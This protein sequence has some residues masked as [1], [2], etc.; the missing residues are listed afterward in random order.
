MRLDA[1]GIQVKI[2]IVESTLMGGEVGGRV[3]YILCFIF[4]SLTCNIFPVQGGKKS[5]TEPSER[6]VLRPPPQK[7]HTVRFTVEG[8]K[9]YTSPHKLEPN[10]S[11]DE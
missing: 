6:R 4:S 11:G 9:T 7:P 8:E 3:I 5:L 2:N 10:T 1:P